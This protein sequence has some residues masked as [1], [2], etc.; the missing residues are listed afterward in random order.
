VAFDGRYLYFTQNFDPT[1]GAIHSVEAATGLDGGTRTVTLFGQPKRLLG[2]AYDANRDMLWAGNDDLYLFPL[3]GGEVV[4]FITMSGDPKLGVTDNPILDRVYETRGD[5]S[6]AFCWRPNDVSC[7]QVT[8]ADLD[9]TGL[10]FDGLDLWYLT[11]D[12]L[13]APAPPASGYLV[14]RNLETRDLDLARA[15]GTGPTFWDIAYDCVTFPVP[16]VWVA[17]IR[18]TE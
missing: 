5:S 15:L 9:S 16:V 2:L 10:A 13:L 1:E 3:D 18:L 8:T 11:S 4:Q 17:G 14:P 6:G 7:G 12:D